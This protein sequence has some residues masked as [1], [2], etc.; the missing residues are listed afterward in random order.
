M[1]NHDMRSTSTDEITGISYIYKW[2]YK[3]DTL[4]YLSQKSVHHLQTFVKLISIYSQLGKVTYLY[5]WACTEMGLY[6]TIIL[7]VFAFCYY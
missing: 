1:H 5:S 4:H 2:N 7:Y 6:C 3:I